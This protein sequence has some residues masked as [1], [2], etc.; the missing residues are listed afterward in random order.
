LQFCFFAH[1]PQEL[2]TPITQP[3]ELPEQLSAADACALHSAI[4]KSAL[5]GYAVGQQV[6][7]ALF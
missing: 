6:N 5:K 3:F 2:R 4:A 7:R 1:T